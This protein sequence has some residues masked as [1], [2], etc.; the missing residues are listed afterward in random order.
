MDFIFRSG[1]RTHQ[2][3]QQN[4]VIDT[5]ASF[6]NLETGGFGGGPGQLSHLAPTYAC[7]NVLAI[8]NVPEAYVVLDRPLLYKWMLSL[9]ETDGSFHMH[10]GGEIDVR[11]V[12]SFTRV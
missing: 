8:L 11:Y 12:H 9:K 6:Q 3:H 2:H 7:I 4:R 5:V 1:T 10:L